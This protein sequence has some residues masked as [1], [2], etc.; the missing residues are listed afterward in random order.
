MIIKFLKNK[1]NLLIVV[2]III[3]GLF[4]YF[5]FFNSKPIDS[6]YIL[7]KLEKSSDLITSKLKYTGM[8]EYKDEGIRFINRSDFVMVYEAEAT[9]GINIKEVDVDVNNI[10]KEVKLIIPKAKILSVNVNMDTIKY[11]D[12]KFSLLNVDP[13]EDAAKA[14]SLAKEEAK[15][16]LEN[17]GILESADEQA[18]LLVKGLLED[19]IPNGYNIIVEKK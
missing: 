11:F 14:T 9:A 1:I 19:A 10:L 6:K 18:E 13:R 2:L 3:I 8:S 12:K 16:E 7:S 15:K 5:K 17:M 4:V